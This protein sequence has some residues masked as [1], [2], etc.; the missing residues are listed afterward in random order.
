M[1]GRLSLRSRS[2]QVAA[3]GLNQHG[4]CSRE[5]EGAASSYGFFMCGPFVETAG[6]PFRSGV[7]DPA[8]QDGGGELVG[9]GVSSDAVWP[10]GGG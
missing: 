2:C 1:S 8:G 3:A 5:F 9:Q 4:Y 10:Y 6:E 7:F